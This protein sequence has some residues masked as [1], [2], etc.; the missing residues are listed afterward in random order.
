MDDD[1]G[2]DP[3]FQ[4]TVPYRITAGTASASNVSISYDGCKVLRLPHLF[5]GLR[6]HDR[7]LHHQANLRA[8]M[9][10][11]VTIIYSTDN[12]DAATVSG[13]FIFAHSN[14]NEI[15]TVVVSSTQEKVGVDDTAIVIHTVGRSDYGAETVSDVAVTVDDDETTG[16][17]FWPTDI[18]LLPSRSNDYTL[19]PD[20]GPTVCVPLTAGGR[21][22]CR[23]HGQPGPVGLPR[24]RLGGRPRP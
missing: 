12:T 13:F 3:G 22:L 18:T 6:E 11:T 5:D 19:F 7:T 24:D 16:I 21:L 8:R 10:M 17:A 4:T 1:E 15:E 23:L 20:S 2:M 14:W 9:Q